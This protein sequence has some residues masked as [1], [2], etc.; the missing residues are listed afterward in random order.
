[1]PAAH[2]RIARST[3]R[4]AE[5][6]DLLATAV[7]QLEQMRQARDF[8]Q[9]DFE[10]A[11]ANVL[12]LMSAH[13]IKTST[14]MR[15][16]ARLKVT[17]VESETMDFNERSLRKALSAPVYDKLCDL[18]LNRQKL[19]EAIADGRVDPVVVASNTTVT[20]RKPY[21]RVTPIKGSE[22]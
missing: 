11:Q 19:E 15:D 12:A 4:A 10:D 2:L 5:Y 9:T 18:K 16:D 20:K 21:V 8:A 14:V 13:K 7:D 1:M 17:V 3:S 6:R 22:Q